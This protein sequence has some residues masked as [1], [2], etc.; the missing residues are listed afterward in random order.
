MEERRYHLLRVINSALAIV[1]EVDLLEEGL[2]GN[3][4]DADDH[5]RLWMGV[6]SRGFF[7]SRNPQQQG[8][9][10][11]QQPPAQQ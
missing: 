9:P 3:D 4:S 1:N 10:R 5:R 11:D 8:P 2:E 7:P 6:R